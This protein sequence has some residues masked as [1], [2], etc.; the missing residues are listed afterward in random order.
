MTDIEQQIAQATATRKSTAILNDAEHVTE[1]L[2]ILTF[3]VQFFHA[4]SSVRRE[5]YKALYS[6]PRYEFAKMLIGFTEQASFGSIMNNGDYFVYWNQSRERIESWFS[7]LEET[8]EDDPKSQ[9]MLDTIRRFFQD[10]TKRKGEDGDVLAYVVVN[11]FETLD[12]QYRAFQQ[13][14]ISAEND[15]IA[16]LSDAAKKANMAW[17]NSMDSFLRGR[18][19]PAGPTQ[20]STG[21]ILDSVAR[22]AKN[23]LGDMVMG[24]SAPFPMNVGVEIDAPAPT[25]RIVSITNPKPIGA[26]P[27]TPS[28]SART[29]SSSAATSTAP[30]PAEESIVDHY[31]HIIEDFGTMML[32]LFRSFSF[33]PIF[34][35]DDPPKFTVE[36]EGYVAL[37]YA[38]FT[39]MAAERYAFLKKAG[40]RVGRGPPAWAEDAI[41]ADKR[42]AALFA[43]FVGFKKGIPSN[44][45]APAANVQRTNAT[46]HYAVNNMSLRF[47]ALYDYMVSVDDGGGNK[48]IR[49]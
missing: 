7:M 38:S 25:S 9:G 27:R 13:Q 3:V 14:R 16:S 20:Q 39:Q 46:Y 6:T 45:I 12:R 37:A 11:M 19:V 28:S 49:H 17:V 40:K 5:R 18:L 44:T 23:V 43:E 47:V 41:Y 1:P 36:W 15:A 32:E 8:I 31:N 26:P 42:A 21:W 48:R 34:T 24:T 29:P 4:Y 10:T 35:L 33:P 22:F 2:Q 30:K